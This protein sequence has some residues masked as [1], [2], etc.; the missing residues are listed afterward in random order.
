MRLARGLP[1]LDRNNI[2]CIIT[3]Y[4][5]E[6]LNEVCHTIGDH[7]QFLTSSPSPLFNPPPP[8]HY[9]ARLG[10]E[11]PNVVLRYFIRLEKHVP[12][13]VWVNLS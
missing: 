8:Q 13:R 5:Y 11:T 10:G 12:K 7:L 6:R 4:M 1:V 2:T 3:S 9:F